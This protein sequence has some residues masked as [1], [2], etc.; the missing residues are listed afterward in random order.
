MDG[1][2][3]KLHEILKNSRNICV[4]TGAGISCPSGIP[5][6]RSAD[7]LYNQKSGLNIPPEEIISHTFFTAHTDLFY[8]FYKSKMLYPDALPNAAHRFFADLEREGKTVS[9]VTQNIDGLH[10]AAGN[11]RVYE[12]HGSVLRNHCMHC[13]AFYGVDTIAQSDGVPHCTKCGGVIKPDVVLYEEPLDEKTVRGAVNAISAA[14]TMVIIG[15][16]LVVYP[17]ASYVRYFG[18]ENLVI[19]NK[20]ATDYDRLAQ[21][22]V[23]DDIVHIVEQ[24]KAMRA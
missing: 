18:G 15:T 4:F 11:S 14:D 23:Y 2:I 5:D 19:L 22:T 9:V 1:K 20:T 3:L 24:V 16:S 7:G 13:G 21:L 12:I 6:F 10:T 8:D 17:A